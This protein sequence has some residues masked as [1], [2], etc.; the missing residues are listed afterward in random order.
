MDRE[1]FLNQHMDDLQKQIWLLEIDQ[2]IIGDM[3]PKLN[4]KEDIDKAIQK[5]NGI[6][7]QILGITN[8]KNFIIKMI[9][10]TASVDDPKKK[11]K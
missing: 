11:D 6:R 8:R 10:G 1:K 5:Q 7:N 9:N 4:K 3:I 2:A